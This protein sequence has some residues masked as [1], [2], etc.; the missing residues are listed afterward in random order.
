MSTWA[1]KVTKSLLAAKSDV[2][3][4]IGSFNLILVSEF[5][6]SNTTV[7][8]YLIQLSGSG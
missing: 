7:T 3:T 2:V 4:P 8:L 5:D 1:F 6:K